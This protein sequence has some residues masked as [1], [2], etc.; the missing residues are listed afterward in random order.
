MVSALVVTYF[1]GLA[2]FLHAQQD[3]NAPLEPPQNN[4][5]PGGVSETAIT[6]DISNDTPPVT[7]QN[8]PGSE[9]SEVQGNQ[10][11][12]PESPSAPATGTGAFLATTSY[13]GEVS[14]PERDPF[15]KPI[16]LLEIE[17]NSKK[18]EQKQ[19]VD[20]D[21]RM[22]A[23]RRWP[24][25]NYRLVGVIWDVKNPKAMIVDPASTMHLLKRNYRIGDKNG[26]ISAISEGAITV[27]QD[28]V[29]V[30]INISK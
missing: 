22:E 9:A 24:L 14:N 5:N 7:D 4:E 2:P 15:R 10:Q 3:I 11:S 16:Y 25:W 17:E 6:N 8:Q 28:N 30:V 27:I 26:I 23:I 1:V 21:E 18:K 12:L 29:P 13:V 20:I 19:S